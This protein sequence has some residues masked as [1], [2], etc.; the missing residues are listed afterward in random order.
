MSCR[1]SPDKQVGVAEITFKNRYIMAVKLLAA[2]VAGS[3]SP[4]R[5]YVAYVQ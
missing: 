2:I 4:S 1:N 3:R 5:K